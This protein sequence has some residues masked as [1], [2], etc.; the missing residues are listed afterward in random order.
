MPI[1]KNEP[2]YDPEKDY[3]GKCYMKPRHIIVEGT[4]E[5]MGYELAKLAQRDYGVKALA[6]YTNDAYGEAHRAYMERNFPNMART[7][8][9]VLRAFDLDEN[10]IEHD[11]TQIPYDFTPLPADAN[12]K[13]ASLFNFC[14]FVNL[15]KEKSEG[16]SVITSRNYDL[17]AMNLWKGFLDLPKE[18]GEYDCWER[19]LVME[20]R[21]TDGG[22]KSILVG[23]M[24]MLN[25][26]VDGM[27]EKG[28]Y[29]TLL[30]DP[31]GKLRRGMNRHHKSADGKE[32]TKR[33]FSKLVGA[34]VV[35]SPFMCV[36]SDHFRL[37]LCSIYINYFETDNALH[38]TTTQLSERKDPLPPAPR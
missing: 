24:E 19:S 18:E 37:L 14:S 34:G 30:S 15:P 4:Q 25:P 20:K 3:P 29:F 35:V 2:V 11:A 6:K 1:V 17:F 21:P 5:E 12:A 28:L 26:Y 7:V 13:G 16:G 23:G 38:N 27:N 22:Y 10:D 8:K 9:G 32:R 36:I 33:R 31:Y